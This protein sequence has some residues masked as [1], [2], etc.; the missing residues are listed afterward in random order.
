MASSMAMISSSPVYNFS[1]MSTLSYMGP[2]FEFSLP[3]SMGTSGPSKPRK[4]VYRPKKVYKDGP[5]PE[6]EPSL[7]ADP[8]VFQL[9]AKVIGEW[10][11]GKSKTK[12]T[13]KSV[14]GVTKEAP[15]KDESL[16]ASKQ[17]RASYSGL[18]G[19]GH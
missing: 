8:N 18:S 14:E 7:A 19:E 2:N 5:Y 11:N 17:S 16:T 15:R 12:N 10:F 4:K 6:L 1:S 9:I 13:V 3:R